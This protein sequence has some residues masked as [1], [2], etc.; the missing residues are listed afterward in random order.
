MFAGEAAISGKVNENYQIVIEYDNAIH[1]T[2][3]LR[4]RRIRW[5]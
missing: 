2:M 3:F 5:S 4:K 1:E